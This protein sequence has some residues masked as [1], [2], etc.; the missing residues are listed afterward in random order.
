MRYESEEKTDLG[1]GIV[2]ER[3]VGGH[4]EVAARSWDERG[5]DSDEIVVHV[6]RVSKGLSGG[7][8]YC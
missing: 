7:S 5:D 1:D 3:S 6:A 4:E 8:H 2:G